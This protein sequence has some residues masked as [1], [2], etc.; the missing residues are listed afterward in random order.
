MRH[1]MLLI[2]F[3]LT[4]TRCHGNKIWD[5]IGYN[6]PCVRDICK[7][8]ASIG[9]FFGDGPLNAA[10]HIFPYWP[11]CHGNDIWDEVGYNLPCARN[12]WEIFASI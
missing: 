12:I 4:D 1:R 7:I 10:N 2:A 11:C 9:G 8:F 3:P 5:K 6:S